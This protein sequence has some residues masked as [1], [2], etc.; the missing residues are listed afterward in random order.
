MPL[1]GPRV[2]SFAFAAALA[3]AGAVRAQAPML[4]YESQSRAVQ[5]RT[6]AE[7]RLAFRPALPVLQ[8][9]VLQLRTAAGASPEA[10]DA[11]DRLVASAGAQPPADARRSLWQAVTLLRGAT[12]SPA[13]EFEGALDFSPGSPVWSASRASIAF[14]MLYP[15]SGRAARYVVDLHA[16]APT[17]SATPQLG[18]RVRTL[19]TG[20]LPSKLPRS[21]PVRLNDVPDGAYLVVATV[22]VDADVAARVVKPVYVVRDLEK[23]EAALLR[24]VAAVPAHEEAKA[25]LAYPFALARG[26]RDGQREIVS[27]DFPRAM[28]R[29]KEIAA[30]L[31]AGR[32]PV[33]QG[34][35]F[36]E[37]AYR[38]PETG[39]LI[40]FQ[41]YVPTSWTPDRRWPLVVALHGANLDE[42]NMLG[43]GKGQM[44]R[45]AEERGF[46]VAA[47]LGYRLNSAYGSARMAMLARDPER[48]RRSEQDVLNVVELVGAEYGV[49][50]ARRYLT[51]NSMGGGG[52]FWIGGRHPELWAAI[53][54]VAFG[55]V[56][57]EDAPGLTTLP[58]Y[59]VCGENDELG[60]LE[61]M[62]ESL[63]VLR[64]AGLAP[65][66]VEIPGGTHTGAFD[67]ALPGIFAFFD[68]HR[69][70]S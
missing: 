11:A 19:A 33:R 7:W 18:D 27:Y 68:G 53:A 21:V 60:M 8:Q 55:G 22:T 50:P 57:P 69:K 67:T 23:R 20:T 42:S 51:G 17:T 2:A 38:F 64:R 62:Q 46:I 1:A 65:A 32:D 66:F 31:A 3:V 24:Q 56:L 6:A 37:R 59:A 29:S 45:L 35:G 13:R 63:V 41:L 15:V 26:V 43:R 28:R 14:D 49:D 40:P 16:S 39:E 10:R 44:Q 12:W 25:L 9:T 54:P 48:A 34:T 5:A 52:T 58:I 4:D 30:A 47:P 36:Q 61:R 70:R